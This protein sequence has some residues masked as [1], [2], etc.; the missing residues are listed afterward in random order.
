MTA[1][2]YSLQVSP[3]SK[4][5]SIKFSMP[6]PWAKISLTDSRRNGLCGMRLLAKEIK[7][8][9]DRRGY[10]QKLIVTLKIGLKLSVENK[11]EGGSLTAAG[12]IKRQHAVVV[13]H[14][15]LAVVKTESRGA[16]P[17]FAQF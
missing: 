2:Q 5:G 13:L 14:E 16:L 12:T 7:N 10:Q 8:Q 4:D 11:F 9:L 3:N 15:H 17:G 1:F 6:C